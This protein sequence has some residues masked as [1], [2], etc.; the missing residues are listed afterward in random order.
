[1]LHLLARN[2]RLELGVDDCR[3]E[4]RDVGNSLVNIVHKGGYVSVPT[5]PNFVDMF[6]ADDGSGRQRWRVQPVQE[7]DPH[8]V[9]IRLDRGRP[10]NLQYIARDSKGGICLTSNASEQ[11]TWMMSMHADGSASFG[12]P[13]PM[14]RRVAVLI[15]GFLRNYKQLPGTLFYKNL[16][17]R[18]DVDL[19]LNVWQEDGFGSNSTQSYTSNP[20]QEEDVRK[21]FGSALK[22]LR[23]T[24]FAEHEHMFRYGKVQ[25]LLSLEPHVLE[26]YRSQFFSF[27]QLNVPCGYDVCIKLRPDLHVQENFHDFISNWDG[28]FYSTKDERCKD[29]CGDTV[30]VGTDAHMKTLQG[31]YAAMFQHAYLQ[32]DIPT[33]P[34]RILF[35]YLTAQ[36]VSVHPIPCKISIVR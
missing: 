9:T 28:R 26:K 18:H 35:H 19:F 23:I 13:P 10:D 12:V 6:R 8:V 36:G 30:F 29:M 7:G 25:K 3:F 32:L 11:A 2:G 16:L 5:R 4:L 34:E 21:T 15:S 27:S 17:A 20:V 1:M 24:R 33:I 31:L 22:A 14:R